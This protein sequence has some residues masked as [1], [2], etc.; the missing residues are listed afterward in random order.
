MIRSSP[1]GGR[2]PRS[3]PKCRHPG[4]GVADYGY[5][6][7]DPLTGRWP[8]RDPI[9]EEGGVNLYGFV[10]NEPASS[11]DRNGLDVHPANTYNI[12]NTIR[13]RIDAEAERARDQREE[14][15]RDRE[16]NRGGVCCDDETIRKGKEEL[17]KK[18]DALKSK[19]EE[20]E[21]D[22]VGVSYIEDA[23]QSCHGRTTEVAGAFDPTPKC[24]QCDLRNSTGGLFSFRGDHWWIEC[25]AY[26]VDGNVADRIN[27]DLHADLRGEG[28][29]QDQD[30][31]RTR[32]K[33]VSDRDYNMNTPRYT[34]CAG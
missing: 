13:S 28:N 21:D 3:R 31:R 9:E 2:R 6:Y 4:P 34:P 8:S 24:W 5:R 14:T 15:E 17:Q 10:A 11:I 23:T 7:Y 33:R 27:F 26:D 25:I 12:P 19:I 1:T 16:A 18:Y 32:K 29:R 22:P 20:T 30:V